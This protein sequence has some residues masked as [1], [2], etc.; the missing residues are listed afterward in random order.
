MNFKRS[1]EEGTAEVYEA[2][3]T[4]QHNQQ[5]GLPLD[6]HTVLLLISAGNPYAN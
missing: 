2:V 6:S 5:Q 3:D 4:R 1:L